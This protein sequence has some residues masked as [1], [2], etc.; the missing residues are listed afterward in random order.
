M[1]SKNVDDGLSLVVGHLKTGKKFQWGNLILADKE[2]MLVIEIAGNEHSIEMS[3]RKVLRT[4]H[5]IMLD[6]DEVLLERISN[7]D[8][9]YDDSVKRVERGYDLLRQVDSLNGVF[10]MLKN[11]GTAPGQTSI[12]R[13]TTADEILSTKMSYV[14]EVD[15]SAESGKLK[16]LFHFANGNPC[17]SEFRAIPLLFPADEEMMKRAQLMYFK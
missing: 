13:H 15:F 7:S 9:L 16:I 12:C 8:D 17:T 10:A 4:G 1:F 14:V 6:T 3:D 5:H 11:H 2:K